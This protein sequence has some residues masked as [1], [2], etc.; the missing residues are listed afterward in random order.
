MGPKKLHQKLHHTL[1]FWQVLISKKPNK[2]AYL[3]DE[4]QGEEKRRI[5]QIEWLD[6]AVGVRKELVGQNEYGPLARVRE[7]EGAPH[8]GEAGFL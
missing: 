2:N 1:W 7:H 3:H 5:I 4:K 8:E 6:V